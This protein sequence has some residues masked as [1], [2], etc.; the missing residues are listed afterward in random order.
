[1]LMTVLI[2]Y[3]WLLVGIFISVPRRLPFLSA[4][5]SC[6]TSTVTQSELLKV[7]VNF[8]FTCEVLRLE[9]LHQT[10]MRSI[11]DCCSRLLAKPLRPSLRQFFELAMPSILLN[12]SPKSQQSSLMHAVA[13]TVVLRPIRRAAEGRKVREKTPS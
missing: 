8:N 1:M 3:C 6:V 7:V 11:S 10:A 2:R 9:E 5:T 12:H 13:Q 4:K